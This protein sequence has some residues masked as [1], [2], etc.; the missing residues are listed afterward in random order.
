M[1]SNRGF[2]IRAAQ[3]P[4]RLTVAIFRYTHADGR[5]DI[6]TGIGYDP[7]KTI[8]LIERMHPIRSHRIPPIV[9]QVVNDRVSAAV[10]WRFQ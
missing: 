5:D 4:I 2:Q 10:E 1:S 8:F 6:R 3:L 9:T 7:E